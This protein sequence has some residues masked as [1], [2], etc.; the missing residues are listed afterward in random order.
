VTKSKEAK[1]TLHQAYSHWI[2]LGYRPEGSI[3]E[4][5]WLSFRAVWRGADV[6]VK[7]N[8]NR[9]TH[10]SGLSEWRIHCEDAREY[11]FDKPQAG[12]DLTD[13]AR[14]RLSEQCEPLVFA[15]LGTA[16]YR[17]SESQAY[18][19]AIKDKLRDPGK[20]YSEEPTREVR[21]L[22]QLHSKKLSVRQY[23]YLLKLANACD[24]FVSIY[25]AQLK[26]D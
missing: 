16:D 2:T 20:L 5:V 6:L 11:D 19:F 25:R 13:T 14:R 3:R 4:E 17:R 23:E 8:A 9:Y 18:L 26:E 7:M 15:W 1:P 22:M 21:E 10:S 12:K 24:E